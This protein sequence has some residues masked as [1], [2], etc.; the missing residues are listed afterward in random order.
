MSAIKKGAVVA[1]MLVG[2]T[3]IGAG[4][5]ASEPS[6][7]FKPLH[8]IS[9]HV[10]SKHA[11]GYFMPKNGVCELTLV[12][13]EEPANEEILG[14]TPTR[15]RASVKAGQHVRFDTGEG[16]ELAF[17]CAQSATAMSVST[18]QQTAYAPAA[19]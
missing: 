17:Y 4:I 11:V 2:F 14:V 1:A 12:V 10:G 6:T 5:A 15:F 13:G 16:K 9:L 19:R 3:S 8:G 7:T 18:M